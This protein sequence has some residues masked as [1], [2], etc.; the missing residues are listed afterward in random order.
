MGNI[1]F[2]KS[3]D[4]VIVGNITKDYFGHSKKHHIGGSSL[5]AGIGSA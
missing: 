5:Y 3:Y 1:I 4:L 2:D